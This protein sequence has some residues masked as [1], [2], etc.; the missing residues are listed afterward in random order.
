MPDIRSLGELAAIA[1]RHFDDQVK[2][3]VEALPEIYRV[4]FVLFSLG[5]QSYDDIAKA[6]DVPIGTVMSRLHRARAQLRGKL[7]EYAR[8]SGDRP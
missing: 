4:P 3:A 6:L 7:A 8:E 5:D 2:A 1:D